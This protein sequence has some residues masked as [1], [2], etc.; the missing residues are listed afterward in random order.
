MLLVS[1]LI[2]IRLDIPGMNRKGR[3][4]KNAVEVNP[5]KK[6]IESL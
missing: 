5:V 6:V 1:A 2:S 3:S 4:K